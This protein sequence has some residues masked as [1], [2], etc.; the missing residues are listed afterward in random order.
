[1]LAYNLMSPLHKNKQPFVSF[2]FN[3]KYT[4]RQEDNLQVKKK[5]MTVFP[6]S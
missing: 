1:M 3:S 6:K 4:F 2:F 5:I